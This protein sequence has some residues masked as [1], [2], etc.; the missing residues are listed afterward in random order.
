MQCKIRNQTVEWPS[1]PP[2][3]VQDGGEGGREGL[4]R[5]IHTVFLDKGGGLYRGARGVTGIA[6]SLGLVL[7]RIAEDCEGWLFVKL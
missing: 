2:L 5:G 3:L 1:A 7:L 6:G 4:V